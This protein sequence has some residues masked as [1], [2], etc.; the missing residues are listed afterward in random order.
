MVVVCD[1]DPVAVAI[2]RLASVGVLTVA[3]SGNSGDAN[4]GASFPACASAAF[5]VG[6]VYDDAHWSEQRHGLAA[7]PSDDG[8]II[9]VAECI[10]PSPQRDTVACYSNG[11][12]PILDI[13]A[14]GHTITAVDTSGSCVSAGATS[15]AAP[16]V[17]AAAALSW[18]VDPRWTRDEIRERLGLGGAILTDRRNQTHVRRLDIANALR[19]L[20][21]TDRDGDDFGVG[22]RC[23]P[24]R[25]ELLFRLHRV[26]ASLLRQKAATGSYYVNH[27]ARWPDQH[28][29]FGSIGRRRVESP[30]GSGEFGTWASER[31][32]AFGHPSSCQSLPIGPSVRFDRWTC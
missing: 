22:L 10:D 25:E 9:C 29:R 13:V 1:F 15:A 19:P 12:G 17:A 14:P 26:T 5:A 31:T 16:H 3:A 8:E 11:G 27:P 24:R 30:P 7:G 6:S 4:G 21:C 32:P 28:Q 20:E 18:S 23:A 2:A